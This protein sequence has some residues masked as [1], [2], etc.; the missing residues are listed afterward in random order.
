MRAVLSRLTRASASG[1]LSLSEQWRM[2][3][4]RNTLVNTG[5][6]LQPYRLGARSRRRAIRG[7]M[8]GTLDESDVN[9]M[10]LVVIC[11]AFHTNAP[12]L[13]PICSL[14]TT[15]YYSLKQRASKDRLS[16]NVY[17][18]PCF[19]AINDASS[20]PEHVWLVFKGIGSTV[21][22]SNA[23]PGFICI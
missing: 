6:Q 10:H 3:L 17:S 4:V 23:F 16:D 15:S 8:K 14:L 12:L 19:E 1:L 18:L 2:P 7:V 21:G 5:D 13:L 20:E 22:P 9:V 11:T